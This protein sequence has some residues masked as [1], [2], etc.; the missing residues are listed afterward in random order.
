MELDTLI[1]EDAKL[2]R[3]A[4]TALDREDETRLRE[5]SDALYA[6]EAALSDFALGCVER[7]GET[8]ALIVQL[9]AGYLA[10]RGGKTD[11]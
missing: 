3:E 4:E 6:A 10:G 2:S 8:L 1:A 7:E 5:M 9:A 11:A